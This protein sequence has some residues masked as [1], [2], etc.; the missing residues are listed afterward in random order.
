[1][2]VCKGDYNTYYR[3]DEPSP[4]GLGYCARSEGVGKKRK[5]NDGE[6]W[7]V[8]QDSMG[9]LAW[10]RASS[11]SSSSSSRYSTSSSRYC[12]SPPSSRYCNS[13]P[14]SRYCDSPNTVKRC[15]RNVK[16][17]RGIKIPFDLCTNLD[18]LALKEYITRHLVVPLA[19]MHYLDYTLSWCTGWD[20]LVLEPRERIHIFK[21]LL[22]NIPKGQEGKTVLT[23][24]G[25]ECVQAMP[26]DPYQSIRTLIMNAHDIFVDI[27]VAIIKELR[28][29]RQAIHNPNRDEVITMTTK[30]FE[31]GHL[32]FNLTPIPNAPPKQLGRSP[33]NHP[34]WRQPLRRP[35]PHLKMEA[36]VVCDATSLGVSS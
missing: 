27:F 36:V 26:R 19:G 33:S 28:A 10:K 11:C 20:Y 1:M 22:D 7:V 17:P 6:V 23:L 12:N 2:P 15:K 35:R 30:G 25:T 32:F 5:G 4:K 3:G 14:S 16:H 24:T 13:P 31:E 18:G 8:R 21:R 34:P 29:G 9:R